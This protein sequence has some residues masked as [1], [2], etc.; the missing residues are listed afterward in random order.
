VLTS[1]L[2]AVTLYREGAVCVRRA[3]IAP[4]ADRQVRVGGFPL[5]ME[6]GSLRARV[7]SGAGRVLDVRPQ[8]DV[9]LADE[10]DVPAEVKALEA[11]REQLAR[12]Q[13]RRARLDTEVSELQSL[14]PSYLEQRRGDAP[15][16]APVTAMIELADFSDAQ[17]EGRLA[18][19]R[20]V[21]EQVADAERDVALRQR[22]VTEASS[23]LKSE[24]ARLSRVAVLMLAEAP[25]AP[26]ELAIEYQVPGVRWVPGYQLK[27]ERGL[28]SGALSMRASIAQDTGE[29]WSGV[30]LALSTAT[31]Q[32]RTDVPELRSLRIG[33]AQAEPPRSGWRAPPAGLDALFEGYDSV[34][35]RPA[36]PPAPA[37]KAAGRLREESAKTLAKPMNL[38]PPAPPP[39]PQYAAMPSSVGG[40]RGGGGPSFGSPAPMMSRSMAAPAAPGAAPM[41]KR[42]AP[43][44]MMDLAPSM[45]SDDEGAM[46]EEL[47]ESDSFSSLSEPS[48]PAFGLDAA[49][50]DYSRL[51][52][53]GVEG[54]G[55]RGQLRPVDQWDSMFAVGVSVQVDVVMTLVAASLGRARAVSSLSLPANTNPVTAIDSFDYRYACAGRLDVPSTGKWVTVPV[56]DCQVGLTPE[57]V[58]VPSV[59]PKVFRTLSVANR[60]PHALLPGPV[61]V[62]VGDD[63]LL[64]TTLPAI[65]PRADATHRLGLG[66]EE[67]IKVSRKTSFKETSG[68]FLGGS[69][70][71]P[72]EIEIELKNGLASASMVEVRERVPWAP[73]DEKDVKIEE[74]QVQ[75]AWEKI[76]KP[77]DGEHVVRGARRWRV[78][79][80][81]GQ[82]M[83]LTAQFTIRLPADRMVVGGNRRS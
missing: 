57:Y 77:I 68:G 35:A 81:P 54:G 75:P 41:K 31:L 73:D 6:P 17:L 52:M 76:E 26:L 80:A 49:L 27:L 74:P 2:D 64:T 45:D 58:C 14:R 21:T 59:E 72:H 48:A 78:T 42:A 62:T 34:N 50:L 22:R 37:P 71:L 23:A 40:V 60:S 56:S 4:S 10:V 38:P 12:L 46:A 15:R 44:E 82:S 7:L 9:Q 65:P 61:D 5:C 19:R 32:R 30:T 69:T 13:L 11:S 1:K 16:P 29:D 28:A 33:R 47:S 24:R 39:M 55:P 79:V 36:A 63:F 8:F 43:A 53:I 67:A 70:L 66:V 18:E 25:T 3:T 20:T 51:T 83:K